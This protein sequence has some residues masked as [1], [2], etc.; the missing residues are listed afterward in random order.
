MAGAPKWSGKFVDDDAS[1]WQILPAESPEEDDDPETLLLAMLAV[2]DAADSD[3][4]AQAAIRE[5]AEGLEGD[6]E[7]DD[8]LTEAA[9]PTPKVDAPKRYAQPVEALLAASMDQGS[10]LLCK[11][12][13]AAVA[14]LAAL[15]PHEIAA[16]RSLFSAEELKALAAELHAVRA[17]GDLLGRSL[18]QDHAQRV[19]SQH[20]RRLQRQLS[21]DAQE[22]QAGLHTDSGALPRVLAAHPYRESPAFSSEKYRAGTD[23]GLLVREAIGLNVPVVLQ[24]NDFSCGRAALQAILDAH[25]VAVDNLALGQALGTDPDDGT[26]PDALVDLVKSLGLPCEVRD[27]ASLDDLAHALDAGAPC[28]CCV[29]KNGGGHWV[30]LVDMDEDYVYVMDPLSGMRTIPAADWLRDWHDTA[31]GKTYTR[32]AL[33]VGAPAATTESQQP[34]RLHALLEASGVPPLQP[35]AALDFF[36]HLVPTLGTDPHRLD[37]GRRTAFTL[38]VATDVELLDKVKDAITQALETGQVAPAGVRRWGDT[39]ATADEAREFAHFMRQAL[40]KA[41]G[42]EPVE[43]GV[44]SQHTAEWCGDAALA[45][46]QFF[47]DSQQWHGEFRPP[48]V[49]GDETEAHTISKVGEFFIDI[50]ADQFGHKAVVVTR[51]ANIGPYEGYQKASWPNKGMIDPD[52]DWRAAKIMAELVKQGQA[53]GDLKRLPPITATKAIQGLIDDAGVSPAN[54]DY[55]RMTFRTNSLDSYNTGLMDELRREADTFPAW[56]YSAV[57]D[58]R[59]RP[60]HAAH[61]GE[62]YAASVPFDQIRGSTIGDKA[63]CRCTLIP[64]DRWTVEEEGLQPVQPTI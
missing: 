14:R 48:G 1:H 28:I 53:P 59:S 60:W 37:D 55:A 52:E 27:H 33:A 32:W 13:K 57:V 54:P 30:T 45:I 29:Q 25:G 4:E 41:S 9:Q 63:N 49:V 5:I 46:H 11:L 18:L 3:E 44:R 50:S 38:A 34:S 21:N 16:A 31:G 22:S 51:H 24:G 39:L 47:P 61:D 42:Y 19:Q 26:Q 2:T 15:P 58:G 43:P 62:V 10:A 20:E 17:S 7:E 8:G 23:A 56:K 6:D 12:A 35:E 36:R 64:L 40:E